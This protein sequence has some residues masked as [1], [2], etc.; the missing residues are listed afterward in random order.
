MNR[1]KYKNDP[2]S[3]CYI[4]GKVTMPDQHSK[5]TQLAKSCYHQAYFGIRIGDQDKSFPPHT[6]CRTFV[7]SLRNWSKDKMKSLPFGV[8]MVWREGTDHATD[9]YFCMT[10]LQGKLVFGSNIHN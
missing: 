7:G 9:C 4:C 10:N 5:I 2:N 8:P 6:C 3:F 1:R